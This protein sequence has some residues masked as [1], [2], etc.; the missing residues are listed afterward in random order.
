MLFMRDIEILSFTLLLPSKRCQTL[1]NCLKKIRMIARNRPFQGIPL[2]RKSPVRKGLSES[3][4][5]P[6]HAPPT[7]PRPPCSHDHPQLAGNSLTLVD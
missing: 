7:V 4:T 6:P 5:K 3:Q 1:G 2:R